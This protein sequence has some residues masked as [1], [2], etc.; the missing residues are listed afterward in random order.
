ME[1]AR[2]GRMRATTGPKTSKP[3]GTG[4]A[5]TVGLKGR[6]AV[7]DG[8]GQAQKQEEQVTQT[9]S[10]RRSVKRVIFEAGKNKTTGFW[11][12]R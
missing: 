11:A 1:P 4:T 2:G 8:T 5:T 3:V 6:M 9:R 10:G 12:Y 7:T